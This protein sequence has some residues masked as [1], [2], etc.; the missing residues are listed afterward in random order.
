MILD[1]FQMTEEK[2][3][4]EFQIIEK[5]SGLLLISLGVLLC[6]NNLPI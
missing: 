3:I 6:D 4:P 5:Y 1:H 2:K